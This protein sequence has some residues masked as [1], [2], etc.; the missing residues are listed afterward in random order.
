MTHPIMYSTK[1]IIIK[2]KYAHVDRNCSAK[3]I[4]CLLQL[5]PFRFSRCNAEQSNTQHCNNHEYPPFPIS[6]H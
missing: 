6:H 3:S 1:Q 5:H 2:I 4:S